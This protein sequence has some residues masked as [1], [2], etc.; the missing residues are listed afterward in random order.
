M[1]VETVTVAVVAHGRLGVSVAGEVLHVAQV[2]AGVE[3]GGDRRVA[4][5]VGRHPPVNPGPG[6]EG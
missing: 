2:R 5:G 6:R 4:K 3:G 1:A